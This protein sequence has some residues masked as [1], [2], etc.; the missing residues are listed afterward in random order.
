MTIEQAIAKLLREGNQTDGRPARGSGGES[1]YHI[2]ALPISEDRVIR[3]AE[4][5]IPP[6]GFG[7]AK[8]PVRHGLESEGGDFRASR[9]L[10]DL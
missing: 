3:W 8:Y 10:A 6:Q 5:G 1:I 4:T 7:R 2:N 9:A